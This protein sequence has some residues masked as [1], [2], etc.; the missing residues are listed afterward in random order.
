LL[1][2]GGF[3][4]VLILEAAILEY[5][6]SAGHADD[7]G[8]LVDPSRLLN[9]GSGHSPHGAG[10]GHAFGSSGCDHV[11]VN[12]SSG[13]GH[14]HGAGGGGA[15]AGHGAGLSLSLRSYRRIA[16]TGSAALTRCRTG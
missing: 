16:R 12:V 7:T 14:G 13:H 11:L 15:A 2:A 9:D 1:A 10:H 8:E 3:L 4:G 6:D 5:M